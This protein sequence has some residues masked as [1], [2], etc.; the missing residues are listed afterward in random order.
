MF[1]LQPV[2]VGA[3]NAPQR[4]YFAPNGARS[5][6]LSLVRWVYETTLRLL[7]SPCRSGIEFLTRLNI[8]QRLC[9]FAFAPESYP[10][11]TTSAGRMSSKNSTSALNGKQIFSILDHIAVAL[12]GEEELTI[13]RELLISCIA[14]NNRIEVGQSAVTL[15]SQDTSKSLSL[16]LS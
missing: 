8:L 16:F 13:S 14:C 2:E 5:L 6:R 3:G 12:L 10:K 11:G 9:V 15:G 1:N 4:T 7:T